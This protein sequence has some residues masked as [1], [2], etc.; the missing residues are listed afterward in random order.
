MRRGSL[1]RSA[2]VGLCLM[3]PS[4]SIGD[5]SVQVT[6]VTCEAER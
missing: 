1:A 6:D 3:G 5:F 2:D 4:T